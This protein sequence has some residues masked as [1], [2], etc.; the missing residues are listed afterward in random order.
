MAAKT[1]SNNPRPKS[2]P[3]KKFPTGIEG[4]DTVLRGG[5]PQG[6]TTA[7]VGGPGS[8]KSSICTNIAAN[9]AGRGDA[10]LYLSFEVGH[11]ATARDATS[12][13]FPFADLE[14]SG[15]LVFVDGRPL[16]GQQ[17]SGE[18]DLGGL[19]AIV[20][21]ISRENKCKLVVLDSVEV[22]LQHFSEPEQKIQVLEELHVWLA[23]NNFTTLVTARAQE[24]WQGQT[25]FGQVEFL[26]DCLLY[27]DQRVEQELTTRRLRVIKYRGSDSGRNE[28]PFIISSSG[29]KLIALSSAKLERGPLARTVSSGHPVLDE[30]L[31]GGYRR[32]SSVL[33]TGE[34]GTGKTTFACIFADAACRKG[35]KVLYV[36]FEEAS[37][38]IIS[39][40]KSS[41]LDLNPMVK[42]G[43]LEF[44]TVMPESMGAEEHLIQLRFD[45]PPLAA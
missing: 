23:E 25:D 17:K 45:T 42:K 20:K 44:L 34:T 22:L 4:L 27:L 2:H 16:L 43:K 21:G 10:C 5:L 18:F 30:V 37:Q 11:D 13:G 33:M 26:A 28:Y 14:K 6:R 39:E 41:G 38:A 12:L 40:M 24:R 35:E 8:G 15:L 7:L 29:T 3:V 32:G 1:P 36:G 19:L 31:G 9:C